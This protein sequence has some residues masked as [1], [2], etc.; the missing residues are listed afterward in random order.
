MKAANIL[1]PHG[2]MAAWLTITTTVCR[3]APRHPVRLITIKATLCD[4]G[5]QHLLSAVFRYRMLA[6]VKCLSAVLGYRTRLLRRSQC[7]P[8]GLAIP[9]CCRGSHGM[10]DD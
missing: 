5:R 9:Q 7:P 8:K 2:P 4:E 6:T 1:P 10:D 3:T